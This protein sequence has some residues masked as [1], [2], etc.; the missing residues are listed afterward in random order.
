MSF[1]AACI[2]NP[3]FFSADC[4]KNFHMI[5]KISNYHN[6][7]YSFCANFFNK[8]P[9]VSIFPLNTLST[10]LSNIGK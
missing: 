2:D 1:T 8:G 5:L 9:I 10:N 6:G 4:Y 3:F 7:L